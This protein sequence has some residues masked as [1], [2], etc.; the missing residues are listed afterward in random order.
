LRMDFCT[1]VLVPL[2][3]P[4]GAELLAVKALTEISGSSSFIISLH[5]L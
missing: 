4:P 2:G 3:L 1:N 5:L